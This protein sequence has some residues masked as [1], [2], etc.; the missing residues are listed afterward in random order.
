VKTK[1]N[2]ANNSK[3]PTNAR[4]LDHLF[5][6]FEN[7]TLTSETA[8]NLRV[9][10]RFGIVHGEA[11]FT[12]TPH[13][14]RKLLDR[15]RLK[16]RSFENNNIFSKVIE[17]ANVELKAN[18]IKQGAN[19]VLGYNMNLTTTTFGSKNYVIVSVTGT[20]VETA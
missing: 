12:G 8:P 7:V 1:I 17:E 19:A 4:S 13:E 6:K 5:E 18:A 10:K 20:A 11:T 14:K 3:K 16:N 2:A 9:R 15:L